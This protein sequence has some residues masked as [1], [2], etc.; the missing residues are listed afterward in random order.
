MLLHAGSALG[1]QP[2]TE[3]DGTYDTY[4]HTAAAGTT[5]A[6]AQIV[7]SDGFLQPEKKAGPVHHAAKPSPA[8]HAAIILVR[9]SRTG[10]RV[11]ATKL[12]CFW[13]S[14]GQSAS[15]GCPFCCWL[16]SRGAGVRCC[17]RRESRD[18]RLLSFVLGFDELRRASLVLERLVGDRPRITR[19]A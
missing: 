17:G 18:L 4:T 11:L 12:R 19:P 15:A 1:L 7:L 2:A 3:L 16:S 10:E 5:A 14:E 9:R 6:S 8:H 13:D